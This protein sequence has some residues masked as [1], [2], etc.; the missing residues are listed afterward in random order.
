MQA[1]GRANGRPLPGIGDEAYATGNRVVMRAGDLTLVL[2]VGQIGTPH[3][4]WL[5]SRAVVS[6]VQ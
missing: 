5:L 2:S 3:L 1:N 4:P 6:A